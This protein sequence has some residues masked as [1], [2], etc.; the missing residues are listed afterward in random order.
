MDLLHVSHLLSPSSKLKKGVF[1]GGV[2]SKQILHSF[3][4]IKNIL[5]CSRT[6]INYCRFKFYIGF[7][8]LPTFDHYFKIIF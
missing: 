6:A 4:Y 3:S 1:G 7:G 5:N 2:R 8:Q